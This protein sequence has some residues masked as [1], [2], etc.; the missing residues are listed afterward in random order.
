MK[1]ITLL[2]FMAVA[3][4]S[5]TNMVRAQVA[6]NTDGTDPNASAMLD[7]KSTSKGLLI[8]RMSTAQRTALG[9]IAVSGLMVYDTDL[10]KFYYHNGTIW[11][12]GST[13]NLWSRSGSAT[14]ITNTN[15]NVGIGTS[16]PGY[17]S[18]ASKYLTI[19]TPYYNNTY[20]TSLEL[21]GANNIAYSPV[22]RIDFLTRNNVGTVNHI[23]RIE[24]RVTASL[25]EGELLFYTNG[26]T[27]SEKMRIDEDGK[28]GIGTSSPARTM[29]IY[30][31]GAW[32][33]LRL[34]SAMSGTSIEFLGTGS[35]AW[36]IGTWNNTI[37]FYSSTTG[38]SSI[39]EEYIMSQGAFTSMV[40]NTKMMGSPSLRWSDVYGVEG[41]F[42][43][44]VAI[45]G[46]TT[47]AGRAAIGT[48][49]LL[50]KL[51]VHDGT[52]SNATFYITPATTSS[53]DSTTIFMAE[54]HNATYGMY[55]LYDG[56][57]NDME[58]WGQYQATT[59]GP[60]FIVGRING[61]AA[62]GST[63]ATGYKLS[64]SGKIIC[65][66]VRV[67]LTAAWPDYVFKKDYSLMPLEQLG[68]FIDTH[69]HL[70]NVP[71]ATE[72]EQSGLEVGEMQ[73]LMME[74]IEELSLYIIDQQKLLTD[75]QKQIRELRDQLNQGRK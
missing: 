25:A 34:N 15:D 66:E 58:L 74:K 10:N 56:V 49:T 33:V 52:S 29:E 45:T 65:E 61:N 3:Y 31:G 35:P 72:L 11:L 30:S 12:E 20:I 18:G 27:L 75:Q 24:S 2:I 22:D 9:A 16:I 54:D 70:P 51:H 6:I 42:S 36:G 43:G 8:P 44:N 37:R 19:A 62:F 39:S 41:D 1:K 7:V 53:Q 60:H 4:F 59:Y 71:S 17:V 73:R 48:T 64:V 14:F 28:V 26:G 40:N 55:W 21:L 50:G 57:G 47:I 13:G 38:F 46:N 23:G 69:G 5:A 63:L 67:A 68:E 32:P